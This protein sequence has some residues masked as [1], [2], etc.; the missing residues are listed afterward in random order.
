QNLNIGGGATTIS[1][2]AE[3]GTTSINNNLDIALDANIDGS[4]TVGGVATVGTLSLG[5]D[6]FTSL[7]GDGLIVVDGTLTTTLGDIIES[8]DI[9]DGS[10]TAVDLNTTNDPTDNYVLTYDAASG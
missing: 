8:E 5:G 10:I 2:G 7:T 4:L 3:S 6:S 9:A 1:L